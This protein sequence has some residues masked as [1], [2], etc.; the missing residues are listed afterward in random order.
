[1]TNEQ[2]KYVN[3][4]VNTHVHTSHILSSDDIIVFKNKGHEVARGTIAN[5]SIDVDKGVVSILTPRAVVAFPCDSAD[6]V[7]CKR[8]DSAGDEYL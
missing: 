4:L 6:F 2:I 5:T 3:E 1:M 8:S 7:V